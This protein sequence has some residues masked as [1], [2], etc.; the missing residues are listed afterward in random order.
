[1][2]PSKEPYP[3][4]DFETVRRRLLAAL[5]EDDD[6]YALLT[7]D[8][9]TGKSTLMRWLRTALDRCHFRVIYFAHA[10]RLSAPGM[11]RV[12]AQVFRIS[13]RRSHSE[14][15]RALTTH[16]RE[17]PAR[18]LLFFDEA[19][20][21]SPETLDEAR[22]LVESDLDGARPLRML[23][24]GL[25]RLREHL[26]A[27]PSLWRRF[28]IREEIT[29][30][31]LDEMPGFLRHHFGAAQAKRLCKEGLQIL[32]ERGRGTPGLVHP[33]FRTL[34]RACE[35][36]TRFEPAYLEDTLQRWDLV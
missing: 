10:S 29:G 13:P 26:Q 11:I 1:M 4:V 14:T 19:H 23:L 32:F 22:T 17:E 12:L 8:S 5:Q 3:F 33:M 25:P 7:G 36:K 6:A 28:V 20:A 31:R 27:S 18:I 30:L 2:S 35:G 34:I 16:L 24:A 9:G 15:L 21:L